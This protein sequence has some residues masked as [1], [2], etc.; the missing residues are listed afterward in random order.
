MADVS[1]S[2]EMAALDKEMAEEKVGECGITFRF[3]LLHLRSLVGRR[4]GWGREGRERGRERERKLELKHFIVSN[5]WGECSRK[6]GEGGQYTGWVGGL[7]GEGGSNK[8]KNKV[9]KKTKNIQTERKTHT[10]PTHKTPQKTPMFHF[11]ITGVCVYGQQN[12]S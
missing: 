3:A 11:Q 7:R 8:V 5:T 12:G 1:E 10:K 9:R 6:G 4:G 2:L